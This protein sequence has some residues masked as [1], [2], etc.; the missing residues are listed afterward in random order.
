MRRFSKL[1]KR[2]EV[3]FSPDINL[4][5]RCT[6]YG[7]IGWAGYRELPRLWITLDKEIIFDFIKDFTDVQIP[8]LVHYVN[9]LTKMVDFPVTH[10]DI[11][12]INNLIQEYIET[13]ADILLDHVFANDYFGLTDIFKAADRRIGKN[14]LLLFKDKTQNEAVKRIINIRLGNPPNRTNDESLKAGNNGDEYLK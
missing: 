11:S 6:C 12:K 8:S 7:Y 1:K 5:V 13:P 2:I 4:T 14:R 9:N 3:L 10:Y